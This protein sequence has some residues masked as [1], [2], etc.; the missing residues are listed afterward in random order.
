MED[1]AEIRR[2]HRAEGVGVK[3]IAR[4]LGVAGN[5]VR[6]ALR[7]SGPPSYQ[8]QAK[9]SI[10]DAVEPEILKLLRDCPDMAATVVAERNGWERSIRVLRERVAELRPL[11]VP[12]DPCQRTSY[13]PG[14]LAQFDL[15]Q[16]NA[17]IP[18]GYGQSAK[19][20]VVVG[21]PGFSRFVA[22]WMIPS[23]QAHDVLGGHL[24]VLHQFGAL[25]RMVVWDQEGAIG[26]WRGREMAFTPEFQA[27][28][29]TLGIG[30]ML[31]Q[32]GDPEAKG[33]VE[34]ATATSRPA[35]C[36]AGASMTSPTSMAS[37]PAGW[38]RPTTAS[39]PPPRCGPARPW[40]RTGG[41]CCPSRRC[42][43]TRR[44]GSPPASLGTTTSGST[45]TTTR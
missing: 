1:W 13:R 17:D 41:R 32:R 23:R 18:L 12:P 22:G 34:R 30:A 43:P 4:R 6:S 16:P 28:K 37:L 36:P 45:P 20:W 25:P 44:C 42:C 15:W 29:G 5:T 2:L 19:C 14:E 10:V 40:P 11:F 26:R 3:A 35:S 8:R 7:A 9:G 38:S 33:L 39:T 27:F 31:C 21:V 24:Q